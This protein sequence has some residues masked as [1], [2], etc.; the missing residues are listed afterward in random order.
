MTKLYAMGPNMDTTK[1]LL[2]LLGIAQNV[3]KAEEALILCPSLAT[4]TWST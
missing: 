4:V 3:N 1:K 2:T